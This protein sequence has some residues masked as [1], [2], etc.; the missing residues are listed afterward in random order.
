MGSAPKSFVPLTNIVR[1]PASL[2][3]AESAMRQ[4]CAAGVPVG[5]VSGDGRRT[6]R[7]EPLLIAPGKTH[8]VRLWV[9]PRQEAV[10][11]ADPMGAWHF[12]LTTNRSVRSIDLLDLYGVAPRDRAAELAIAGAFTRLVTNRDESE[13]LAKIVNSAPGTEHQAVWTIRRDDGALRAGHFACRIVTEF[14]DAGERHVLLRGVT[15]DIGAA[16]AVSAAPPPTIL[17]YAVLEAATE[18]G[19]YR[20]I[21]NLRSLRLIRWIGQPM[22]DIAWEDLPGQPRPQIHPEDLATAKTMSRDLA[23]HRTEGTVRLRRLDGGWQP[24]RI[25]AALMALDQH[26]TAGLATVTA[27]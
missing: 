2:A 12:D 9:G 26:T 25:R 7:A 5:W 14:D 4:A 24:V 15:Q 13:A 11:A 17:E 27:A 1:N 6:V 10:A 20:A 8:A 18:P 19:E 23:R 16:T 21:V 22:P 3:D